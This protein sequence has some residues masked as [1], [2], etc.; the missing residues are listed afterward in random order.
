MDIT[1]INVIILNSFAQLTK[2][3]SYTRNQFTQDN[4]NSCGVG[5]GV[6]QDRGCAPI[7]LKCL[8]QEETSK[9]SMCQMIIL[10]RKRIKQKKT[11]QT[12]NRQT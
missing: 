5:M 6:K 12:L 2:Q 4:V 1:A 3:L 11:M 10:C 9:H 8:L 7:V